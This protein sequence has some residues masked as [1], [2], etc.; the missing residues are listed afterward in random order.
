MGEDGKDS[1]SDMDVRNVEDIDELHNLDL[2]AGDT[3]KGN[4]LPDPK[5][6]CTGKVKAP[7]PTPP[8]RNLDRDT[9]VAA[10][11]NGVISNADVEFAVRSDMQLAL[12]SSSSGQASSGWRLQ[13]CSFVRR[14]DVDQEE[15]EEEFLECCSVFPSLPRFFQR[16]RV[17]RTRSPKVAQPV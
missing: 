10:I 8:S 15:S 17:I 6:P 1:V 16:F 5:R 4:P 13:N 7:P 9:L 3:R 2:I 14:M 12:S 11:R